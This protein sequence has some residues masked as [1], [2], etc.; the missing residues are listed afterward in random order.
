[1]K[2]TVRAL[3]L[4]VL[5]VLVFAWWGPV[6]DVLPS[7]STS[8]DERTAAPTVAASASPSRPADDEPAPDRTPVEPQPGPTEA[9]ITCVWA[10]DGQP[11]PAIPVIVYRIE[12]NAYIG[13]V[14]IAA[15]DAAGIAL[16]RML[17]AGEYEFRAVRAKART[18]V[19]PGM[20]AEATLTVREVVVARGIVV[21]AVGVPMTGAHVVAEVD[22]LPQEVSTSDQGRASSEP[23]SRSRERRCRHCSATGDRRRVAPRH[24]ARP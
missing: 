13:P 12:S 14:V 24:C 7:A 5:A 2:N 1:M 16:F 6:A 19:V 20:R 11:A 23:R 4:A 21:D 17:D 15:T 3:S 10:N 22:Y 8:V 18:T 9:R